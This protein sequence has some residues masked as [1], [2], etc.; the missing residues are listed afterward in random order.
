MRDCD[1]DSA[2]F[3]D[4]GY[5][6]CCQLLFGDGSDINVTGEESTSTFVDDVLD[7]F[8]VADDVRISSDLGNLKAETGVGAF[9][10]L[11]FDDDSLALGDGEEG[12]S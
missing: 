10:S 1:V 7:D 2:G 6:I 8:S 5:S 3:S 11:G 4:G 9:F 12:G